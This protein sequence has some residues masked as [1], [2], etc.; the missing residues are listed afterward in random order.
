[1]GVYDYHREIT[2]TG[3]VTLYEK[4]PEVTADN[5]YKAYVDVTARFTRDG[6]LV[7]LSLTWEDGRTYE[8]DRVRD[9]QRLASRKAGGAGICYFCTVRGQEI[10]LFYEMN[11]LWFVTRKTDD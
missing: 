2:V 5:P 3:P 4:M 11:G 8:I 1:M 9:V 6:E 7:P 10:Q